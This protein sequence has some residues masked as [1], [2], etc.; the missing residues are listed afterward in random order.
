M[1]T[2]WAAAL[3]HAA[4][5]G[6]G[7]ADFWR[8]SVVEWRALTADLGP[9]PLTRADLDTLIHTFPDRSHDR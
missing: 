9:A 6:F 3:A 7:P 2:N 5:L 8:F 4:R 1:Q